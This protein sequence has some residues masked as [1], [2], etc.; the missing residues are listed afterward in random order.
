MIYMPNVLDENLQNCL[1]AFY[2]KRKSQVWLCNIIINFNE[3][4]DDPKFLRRKTASE[5]GLI[6]DTNNLSDYFKWRLVQ[7]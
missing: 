6:F 2:L 1:D 3:N 7:V 4:I 5:R